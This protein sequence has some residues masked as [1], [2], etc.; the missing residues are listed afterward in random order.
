MS[1]PSS[2]TTQQSQGSYST[3]SSPIT[4]PSSSHPPYICTI[5]PLLPVFVEPSLEAS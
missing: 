2:P 4:W 1:S 5:S 3:P